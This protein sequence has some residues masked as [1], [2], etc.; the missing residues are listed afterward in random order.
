MGVLLLGGV[1]IAFASHRAGVPALVGF[2]GLGM[3]LGSGGIG[4]IASD[5]THLARRSA[6]W[7]WR[8]LEVESGT[9]DP[10]TVALTPGLIGMLTGASRRSISSACGSATRPTCDRR[11]VLLRDENRREMETLMRAWEEGPLPEPVDSGA[12]AVQVVGG[13]G[14]PQRQADLPEPPPEGR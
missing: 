10:V 2:L 3:L 12:G 1:A 13:E 14:L 4:G 9:N 8:L 6:W 7:P 11:Y 5:D